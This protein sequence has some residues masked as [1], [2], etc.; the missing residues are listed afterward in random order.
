MNMVDTVIVGG[1]L[2]GLSAA[3]ILGRCTRKVLLFDD[4]N[5]RNYAVSNVNG[6]ITQ[7]GR[8]PESLRNAGRIDLENYDVTIINSHVENIEIIGEY[9]KHF[10]IVYYNAYTVRTKSVILATG[11]KDQLPEIKGLENVYGKKVFHCEICDGFENRN[12][13]IAVHGKNGINLCLS[14]RTW[15]KD[16][17]WFT[18]EELSEEDKNIAESK[19]IKI[20]SLSVRYVF[21]DNGCI[22]ICSGGEQDGKFLQEE[23]FDALFL[24]LTKGQKQRSPLAEKMGLKVTKENGIEV[25]KNGSTEIPGLYAV[26]DCSRDRLLIIKGAAEGVEAGIQVNKYLRENWDD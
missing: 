23:R 8:D 13:K 25:D 12:K 11:L 7:D 1:G 3:L 22:R 16:I 10:F 14:L 6:F 4:G 26:G 2:S 24:S 17:T 20:N 21:L 15:S 18:E 9:G 5:Y 19:N